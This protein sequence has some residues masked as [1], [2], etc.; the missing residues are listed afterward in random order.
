[1]H[2]APELQLFFC[3]AVEVVGG[4]ET[5]GVVVAS[6]TFIPVSQNIAVCSITR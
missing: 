4:G 3:E 6:L 5:D 2:P 1:V